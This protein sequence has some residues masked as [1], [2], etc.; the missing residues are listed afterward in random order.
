[1]IESAIVSASITCTSSSIISHTDHPLPAIR[2]HI[3]CRL[4]L[5]ITAITEVLT[6]TTSPPPDYPSS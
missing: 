1:M 4:A 6:R 3:A 5:L 2:I